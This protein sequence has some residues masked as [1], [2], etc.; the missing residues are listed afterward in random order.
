MEAICLLIFVGSSALYIRYLLWRG[1]GTTQSDRDRIR[2]QEGVQLL[3]KRLYKEAFSYFN[4][5][6]QKE[7]RCAL[8]LASR[9]RCYLMQGDW[10]HAIRDC[11]RAASLDHCLDSIYLDKGIALVHLGETQDAFVQFDKAVW[12]FNVN[13]TPNADAYRW[14]GITR[15]KLGDYA[16]A[17][18]DFRKAINLGDENAAYFLS[19]RGD[20]M[21]TIE[22]DN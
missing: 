7:P 5:I 1:A 21:D 20:S 19:L 14:R 10:L 12:Y 18:Q 8:A 3:E 16:K 22:I 15:L 4:S 17:E 13:A 9:A 6:L 11:N 2:L